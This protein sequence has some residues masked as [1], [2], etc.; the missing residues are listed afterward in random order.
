MNVS[1]QIFIAPCAFRSLTQ[2]GVK[3]ISEFLPVINDISFKMSIF[4]LSSVVLKSF[5]NFGKGLCNSLT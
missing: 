1:Q 3:F 2:L 4:V 5:L